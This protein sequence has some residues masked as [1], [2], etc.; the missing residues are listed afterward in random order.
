L[1]FE[2]FRK[3]SEIFASE[4]ALPVS[5]SL[6]ANLPWV[7]MTPVAH[8]AASINDTSGKFATCGNDAGDK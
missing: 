4:G 5:T 6:V 3:F 8:F 7:L 1:N 2:F